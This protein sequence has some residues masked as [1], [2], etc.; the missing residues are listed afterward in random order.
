MGDFGD[1]SDSASRPTTLWHVGADA[2]G[3]GGRRFR[4]PGSSSG[5]YTA[6]GIDTAIGP[7]LRTPDG[8]P[9]AHRTE[10]SGGLTDGF[11][12]PLTYTDPEE[13]RIKFRGYVRVFNN[14]GEQYDSAHIRLIVGRINLVEKIADLATRWGIQTPQKEAGRYRELKR[15][16][17]SMAFDKASHNT[18]PPH[19]RD[20][21]K[22][23]GRD[24]HP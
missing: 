16:A 12:D 6:A 24:C 4:L 18:F 9:R 20:V 22:R 11:P 8:R 15:Q 7:G 3:Q 21:P 5:R 23:R 14:S 17:A 19:L 13:E 2:L 10:Q 1:Q